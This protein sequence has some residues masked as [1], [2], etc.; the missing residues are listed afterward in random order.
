VDI[1][2]TGLLVLA[3]ALAGI[4]LTAIVWSIVRPDRRIWPPLSYVTVTPFV[5]WGVTYTLFGA[6]IALGIIGWGQAAIA[7]RLQYGLGPLLIILGNLAVW[8][9]VI[10]FGLPQTGGAVGQLKIDGL[11]RYSR[12]PQY[13]ADIAILIG[14]ALFCASLVALPAIV[15]GIFILL[16]APIAEEPWLEKHY[17]N[18]YLEYK[19]KVRR[20]L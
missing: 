6:I 3:L 1:L 5:V 7:G 9:E 4:T 15:V 13:I 16:V 8:T 2:V 14:W 19:S 10:R 11:Y 18:S 12:N 20:Y 17:G